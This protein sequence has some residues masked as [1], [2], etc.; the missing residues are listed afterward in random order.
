[1]IA[2]IS[3]ILKVAQ[4]LRRRIY[5]AAVCSFL[6]A[7][8][9]KAP[10][11]VMFFLI[12]GFLNNTVTNMSCLWAGIAIV[13]CIALQCMFQNIADRLQSA[14]GFEIFADMRL[15]LGEHLRKMP[16][17]FFTEG[18]IGRISSV[19][20]TDMNFIEENLM[21]VL[22][23]LMSYIFSAV[24]FI[25]FLFVFDWR[26]GLLGLLIT[27]IVFCI[28]EAM[29]KNTL[30]HSN[31]R[32]ETSQQLT[33]A[34]IDF[35]EGMGIIKT[36]NMLGEK[37]KELTESFQASCDKNLSFEFDFA[38]WAKALNLTCGIGSATMLGA[39]WLLYQRESLS[40]AFFIGM[41]LFVFELFRPLKAFYGQVARL[42]VMDACLDR[43]EAIFAEPELSDSGNKAIPANGSPEIEF[44]DVSFAYDNKDVLH[45]ISFVAQRNTMTALVG[46][47]G[48]GKSTIASLL[49][50]FWDVR[51]G[52]IRLRGKNIRE[53]PLAQVMDNIS[54]VFQRVY[55]FQDTI[56]NN[57]AMGRTDA[58]KEEVY[59]AAKK[60]RCY[61]F[62]MALPQG[63]DTMVG[64]GGMSLS[65]GEQQR[66][67]IA[68]CILKDAPII[69]LD[70]AT[71]SV[72]A[73]NERCIQD[74]I[75]ELVNN[76]TVL[77][78]AHRLHTIA[79]ADQI[80]VVNDGQ[81]VERGDHETL[82]TQGGI[83]ADMVQKRASM[84]SFMDK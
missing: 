67:S 31:E 11:V 61:D 72:D 81:I 4:D 46:P 6:K 25:L 18:N 30:M 77:V 54:M 48:G 60:A 34:V 44:E 59:T 17:G 3:R 82:I 51:E 73:D 16:M 83:Y 47:S 69:V 7:L 68:R 24:I 14:A 65:G 66:I 55:L 52:S 38:P 29:K 5:G 28:G 12:M 33:E 80:L 10:I 43:I 78:I 49:A 45:K 53:V 37:S 32:Q 74:A 2:F 27:S 75:S 1:M 41:L 62:I 50:R 63:F 19:L 8:L 20:S 58:S 13:T 70:E 9:G 39:M 23:D 35:T 56:Y 22:A 42:T 64:E 84:R 57:I 21:M 36:Y 26:L 71:A 40:L 15:K 79:G 76:K